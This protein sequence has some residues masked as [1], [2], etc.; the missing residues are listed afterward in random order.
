MLALLVCR[1]TGTQA[2]QLQQLP[3]CC[4]GPPRWLTRVGVGSMGDG[5]GVLLTCIYRLDI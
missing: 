3:D 1:V 5:G 4:R 2:G